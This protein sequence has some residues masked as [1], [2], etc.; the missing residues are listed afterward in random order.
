[1]IMCETG[2]VRDVTIATLANC[3]TFATAFQVLFGMHLCGWYHGERKKEM[4][5]FETI[6]F[7]YA[8]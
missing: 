4:G 1:M 6:V 5:V 2:I 3:C 7:E 8:F